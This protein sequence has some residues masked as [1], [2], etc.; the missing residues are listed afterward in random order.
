MYPGP[1]L[2]AARLTKYAA[3]DLLTQYWH[4]LKKCEPEQ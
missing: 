1:N 3:Q 4:N 2:E